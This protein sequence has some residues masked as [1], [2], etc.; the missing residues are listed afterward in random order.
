MKVRFMTCIFPLIFPMSSR[1]QLIIHAMLGEGGCGGAGGQP[2]C[3]PL[4][5]CT[6]ISKLLCNGNGQN[7]L[8]SYMYVDSCA[9]SRLACLYVDIIAT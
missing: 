1:L 3:S 9:S 8:H 4:I 6:C 5:F 7:D 2:T